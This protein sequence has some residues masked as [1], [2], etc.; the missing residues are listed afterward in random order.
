LLQIILIFNL[1]NQVN[2]TTALENSD[3]ENTLSNVKASVS[4]IDSSENTIFTTS[5]IL[6]ILLI[7]IGF[8]LILLAIA[9]LIR[10]KK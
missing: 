6:N 4:I 7:V 10:L 2:E 8:V 3:N 9:I 5:N 1:D